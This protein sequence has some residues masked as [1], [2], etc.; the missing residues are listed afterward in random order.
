MRHSALI[1]FSN[2]I[3][4]RICEWKHLVDGDVKNPDQIV[5]KGTLFGGAPCTTPVRSPP[6]P[7]TDETI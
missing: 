1:D 3:E 6:S 4:Q 7:R 2:M 5:Q